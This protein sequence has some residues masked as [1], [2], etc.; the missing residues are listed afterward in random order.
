MDIVMVGR[1]GEETAPVTA[2]LSVNQMVWVTEPPME[3][4]MG[5]PMEMEKEPEIRLDPRSVKVDVMAFLMAM[6]RGQVTLSELDSKY[7]QPY[8][9]TMPDKAVSPTTRN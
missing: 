9:A 3:T 1:K 7:L 5:L 8:P 6:A 4:E 2:L